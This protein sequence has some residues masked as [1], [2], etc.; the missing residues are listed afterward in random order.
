M[1]IETAIALAGLLAAGLVNI[2]AAAAAP[3]AE[4]RYTRLARADCR[5]VQ[6]GEP[7]GQDWLLYR[8]KGQGNIPVWV[9]YQDSVRMQV[10]F[11][12]RPTGGIAGFSSDRDEAW[13]VEWR[14][15]G[16]G[17][18]FK[19]YAAILRMRPAGG[20]GGSTLAVYRVWPDNASCLLDTV[21][22]N[23][24]ARALA[25]ASATKIDCD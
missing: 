21:D 23:E 15:T 4:S 7:E 24:A 22:N 17:A 19:P 16:A 13:K 8:C 2:G 6:S 25:D 10:A 3:V 18:K 1:R 12:P 5:V 14:G 9:L 20:D 11:G